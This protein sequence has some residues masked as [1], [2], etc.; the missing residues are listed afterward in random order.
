VH[1]PISQIVYAGA[2]HQVSHVWVAG[3]PLLASG[4]LLTLDE[5]AILDNSRE[6]LLRIRQG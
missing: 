5:Q 4:N 3:K 6:W 1:H 2:R